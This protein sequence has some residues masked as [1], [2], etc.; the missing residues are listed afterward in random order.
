LRRQFYKLQ[1]AQD[2]HEFLQE[3]KYIIYDML[4]LQELLVRAGYLDPTE[5][6]EGSQ[7]SIDDQMHRASEVFHDMILNHNPDILSPQIDQFYDAAT[8]TEP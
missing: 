3:N 1:E 6:L 2:K 5:A 7:E 4:E 8:A